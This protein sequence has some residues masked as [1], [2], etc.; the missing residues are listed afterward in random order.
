MVAHAHYRTSSQINANP[1]REGVYMSPVAKLAF[2]IAVLAVV[3]IPL[4]SVI[5]DLIMDPRKFFENMAR[6]S[7]AFRL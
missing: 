7:R 6:A 3:T 1:K 5:V 4:S 2:A